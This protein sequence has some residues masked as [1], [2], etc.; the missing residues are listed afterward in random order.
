L[1]FRRFVTPRPFP[2]EKKRDG[3]GR[4]V[5]DWFIILRGR[6]LGFGRGFGGFFGERRGAGDGRV[7]FD[8]AGDDPLPT[9]RYFFLTP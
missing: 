2:A 3:G 1:S 8:V 4:P 9:R 6:R 5:R 7:F